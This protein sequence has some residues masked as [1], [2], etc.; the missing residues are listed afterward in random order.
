MG[1]KPLETAAAIVGGLAGTLAIDLF[2]APG[3][4]VLT[5]V[6][7]LGI[8]RRATIVVL[9]CAIACGGV[10]ALWLL[11]T[12]RCDPTIQNCTLE[13]PALL[14]LGWLALGLAIGAGATWILVARSR[15]R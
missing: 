10:L 9:G 5:V 14:M 11:A 2:G 6:L 3:L 12:G 7:I 1:M 15:R 13:T 4:I 8:A